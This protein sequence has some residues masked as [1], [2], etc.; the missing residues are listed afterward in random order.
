[1]ESG[2]RIISTEDDNRKWE[3]GKYVC[4][5]CVHPQAAKMLI[6]PKDQN[7]PGHSKSTLLC[8]AWQVYCTKI[9]MLQLGSILI[10]SDHV[11]QQVIEM[12]GLPE[13]IYTTTINDL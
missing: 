12:E 7:S 11:F 1:M 8:V 2:S 9:L 4:A 5:F 6:Q 13:K 10:S 3:E